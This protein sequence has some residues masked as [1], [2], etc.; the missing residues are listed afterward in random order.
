MIR[1]L[2]VTALSGQPNIWRFNFDF[3][4]IKNELEL[5]MMGEEPEVTD[6]SGG[7]SGGDEEE[8]GGSWWGWLP[9]ID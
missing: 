8:N 3:E 4:I 5:R 7:T 2:T 9:F 1:R 6:T